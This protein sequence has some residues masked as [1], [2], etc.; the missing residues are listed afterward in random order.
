M[1]GKTSD[2][3]VHLRTATNCMIRFKVLT[4]L[5]VILSSFSPVS[6]HGQVEAGKVIDIRSVGL[7]QRISEFV[8]S[9]YIP[10]SADVVSQYRS[11]KFIDGL[12][13]KSQVP[14]EFVNEKVLLKFNLF[15][16]ADTAIS[17]YFFPGYY[18]SAIKLYRVDN[19]NILRLPDILP[20]LADSIGYRLIT[21]NGKDS[22]TVLSELTL[23]KT[24]NNVVKPRLVHAQY[25]HAFIAQLR[26]FHTKNDLITYVFCGLLLMMI[27]FSMASFL[28]GANR[29]FLYYSGYAFFLGMML[30]MQAIY[31]YRSNQTTFFLEGYLDFI[32]QNIGIIFYMIFMQKFL[33][34]KTQYPF[35][36]RLY[37]YGIIFLIIAMILYSGLHYFS[38]NYSME[39]FV[40]NIT[41]VSLL[42]MV[43]IFLVYS[44]KHWDDKLLRYLFWGNLFLFILAMISQLAVLLNPTFK[45]LPDPLSSSV[46][47]YEIGLL[48]ELVF[49]LTG[50]NHKNR[51]QLISQTKEREMLKAQNKLQEYE[52]EIAVYKAQQEER[53]RISADMHDEL[54]SGMTAIRLMSEIARNKMK[55]QTPVEIEKISHSANDV[56]N[57]MNAIIWSMNSGN[58]TLDNL[59]SY[60]REY[61]LEYFDSTPISCQVNTPSQ[62]R[63]TDLSGDKR[64]NIFLSIKESLN[65]VLKHSNAKNVTIDIEENAVL[66]IRISDDGKGIDLAN[67]RKFGNGL[68]NIK[69]RMESIGGSYV[70]SNQNGTVSILSLPMD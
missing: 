3:S 67:L 41:K 20:K 56:L 14:N 24:Y 48:L 58:D 11:F 55:D 4:A 45:K 52:K 40:E 36:Y 53:Q 17:V 26:S 50:L 2:D 38:S 62:I 69:R 51:S 37:K 34:T 49:F 9:T 68:T 7:E 35:L 28:Q 16:P 70:I 23:V 59:I 43:V 6:L 57:K 19:E 30:F 21:V 33:N 66:S 18:F 32:M 12:K 25:L 10:Q 39:N 31:S 5:I 1:T 63:Q 60:I 8:S 44:S 42:L 54:G 27:L 61:A 64:R 46:L 29:E 22:M 13:H 15:N 65:N 47:Y